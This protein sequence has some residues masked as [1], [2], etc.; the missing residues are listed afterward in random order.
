MKILI[1]LRQLVAPTSLPSAALSKVKR[2]HCAVAFDA[3]YENWQ[4][5]LTSPPRLLG[6]EDENVENAKLN[7]SNNYGNISSDN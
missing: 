7:S 6:R 4:C 3:V 1:A 2:R 5:A